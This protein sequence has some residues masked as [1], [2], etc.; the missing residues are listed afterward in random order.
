MSHVV[1]FSPLPATKLFA[2][3]PAVKATVKAQPGACFTC[4]GQDA[5][6]Q[7]EREGRRERER[8]TTL[9]R[10]KENE[11]STGFPLGHFSSCV[12]VPI[13]SVSDSVEPFHAPSPLSSSLPF[14]HPLLSSL[15]L[16]PN[17]PHPL[18]LSLSQLRLPLTA[19][20]ICE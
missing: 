3:L 7:R 4:A 2:A 19:E 11:S 15:R 10:Y 14:S 18:L 17:A 13:H 12:A 16:T 6:L 1:F 5:R 9:Y 8:D 20:L